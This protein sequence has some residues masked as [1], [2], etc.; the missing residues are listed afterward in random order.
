MRWAGGW[1][2][3]DFGVVCCHCGDPRET[4]A[5]VAILATHGILRLLF[6]AGWYIAGS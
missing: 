4:S 6:F 3:S 2:A 1:L 5:F